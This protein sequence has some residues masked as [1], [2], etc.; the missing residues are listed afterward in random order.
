MSDESGDKKVEKAETS[1]KV[2][3]PRSSE[4]GQP[5]IVTSSHFIQETRKSELAMPTRLTTFDIMAED[6]AVFNSIDVTNARVVGALWKGKFV[7]KK[8]QSSKIAAEFLNY[9]IR[10]MNYGT[11]LDA[12]NDSCTDL[13]YGFA[14][15]NIVIKKRNYGQFAGSRCLSKLSPRDQKSVYGWVFNKNE[16]EVLGF[17]QK[18][19]TLRN[20]DFA[21]DGLSLLA[22]QRLQSIDYPFIRSEQLLHFRHNPKSINPQGNSPLMSCYGAW[23]EKKLIEKYEVV[24]ISK[25]LGGCIVLRV[26][27]SLIERANDPVNYPD[28][29]AEY[30]ALQEDAA[31]LHAG[32]SSYIVLTSDVDDVTKTKLYDFELKGIEG[33]GKQ[34]KTSDI[35]DQKRKSIYNVFGA[36]FLLLG[37][38]SVGSYNLSSSAQSTHGA[39][40]ERCIN[41]KVDVINNRLI[42]TLLAVNNVSLDWKD[43][44]EFIP[45][46]PGEVDLDE[47]GKFIQR[48][49]SVNG[50]TKEALEYLYDRAN[51]PTEGIDEIDFSDKGKSRAGESE[52]TSGTGNSQQSTDASTV[53][54]EN[55]GVSKNLILDR[56]EDDQ[57]VLIDVESG[58]PIFINREE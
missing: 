57:I 58:S 35:I 7:G 50:L 47:L 21:R 22:A 5:R 1:G 38:D 40:V 12:V 42:P 45:A 55:G 27:S 30:K 24:G 19:S 56:V 28:E 16:S 6:D 46:D 10:N 37:Q 34:Y 4:V 51:L 9:C 32:E 13:Q 41:Q 20:N 36:G 11:W 44:P 14:L 17:V 33:G 26:P 43:M 8:S 29:A 39:Y 3:V 54:A 48:T 15:Q 52:G 23:K 18:P 53:N 25:D 49:K 31:K 2:I